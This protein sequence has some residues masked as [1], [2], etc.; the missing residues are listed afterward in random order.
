[1]EI[2]DLLDLEE[3]RR[4]KYRYM[5][6]VDSR[7]FDELEQCFAPDAS[8]SYGDGQYSFDGRDNIME[9][10]R[11]SLRSESVTLHI[12]SHPEIDLTSATTANGTWVL[13]DLVVNR[14]SGS[15]LHGAAYY[16][17]TYVK[18]DGEWLI[19]STGYRRIIEEHSTVDPATL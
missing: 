14:R 12:A 9:F 1:M 3:I 16:S 4:L 18:I 11:A 6:C 17:D 2:A 19:Q 10:L 13:E 7:L 8:S 15:R 5:R